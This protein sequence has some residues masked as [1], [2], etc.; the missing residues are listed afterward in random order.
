MHKFKF[1]IIFFVL[2]LIFLNVYKIY[3]ID[4]GNLYVILEEG[5]I[6]F[7]HLAIINAI[8]LSKKL[9]KQLYIINQTNDCV[10]NYSNH[11]KSIDIKHVPKKCL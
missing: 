7:Q 8:Q 11:Y 2:I 4:T 9:K 3:K 6:F 5:G 10:F 1:F